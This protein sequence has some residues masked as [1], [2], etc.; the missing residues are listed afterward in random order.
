MPQ[1]HGAAIRERAAR[2]RAR[3]AEQVTRHLA[4]Q[5]GREHAVL[6]E[7]PRMGRTE[8]FTEVSFAKDQPEGQIVSTRITGHN[9]TRLYA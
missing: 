8:Q 7:N 2:L 4:G 5:I 1:V 6:L 9:E 3:G